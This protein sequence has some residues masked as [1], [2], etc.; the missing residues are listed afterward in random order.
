MGKGSPT[1]DPAVRV[2]REGRLPIQI[3]APD[4]PKA[5]LEMGKKMPQRKK[6]RMTTP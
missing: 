3:Q 4:L 5:E 6:R 2:G 1:P